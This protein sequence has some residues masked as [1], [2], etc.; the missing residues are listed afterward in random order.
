MKLRLSNTAVS[1][2]TLAYTWYLAKAA[3]RAF[4]KKSFQPTR[5]TVYARVG[6]NG[7]CAASHKN[8]ATSGQ[9]KVFW[10]AQLPSKGLF[11]LSGGLALFFSSQLIFAQVTK[12]LTGLGVWVYAQSLQ[13][14]PLLLFGYILIIHI[15]LRH[16]LNFF[17]KPQSRRTVV[18]YLKGRSAQGI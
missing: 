11:A 3:D 5:L 10:R 15:A 8:K 17:K 18:S 14:S 16:S 13:V 6:V 1:A 2:N 4:P 9:N 7:R 12:G